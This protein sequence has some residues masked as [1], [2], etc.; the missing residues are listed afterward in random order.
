LLLRQRLNGLMRSLTPARA[1]DA[2]GIHQ[3]RVA[4][5]RLREALPVLARKGPRRKLERA[6]RTLTRTLGPVRELDVALQTLDELAA[7]RDVPR[8]AIAA[9]RR[10]IASERRALHGELVHSLDRINVEKL[11]RR[12]VESVRDETARSP[13][14]REQA[15]RHLAAART[16]V[17]RRA[18]ALRVA[19]DAA[20]AM[21]L[22]DRLHGVRIAVKKLRYAM[23]VVRD[24]SRSRATA[25]L[26]T[27]K[28]TQDLLGRMHDLEVLIARTRAMQG[29][30]GAPDLRVSAALDTLVRRL[31]TECRQLHARYIALRPSLLAICDDADTTERRRRHATAA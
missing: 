21:Y 3:A 10:S 20:A 30:P 23:E 14:T 9:L 7:A 28:R 13:K 2:D 24:L 12:A 29:A 16:R 26:Q 27:L 15:A 22:P 18:D 31:E 6:A 11:Q 25:R 4:T 17:A 5:R 8:R 1:G 19:I